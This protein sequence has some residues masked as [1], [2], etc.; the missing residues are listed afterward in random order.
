MEAGIPF[1]LPA[2]AFKAA[3]KSQTQIIWARRRRLVSAKD[4][5]GIH[6]QATFL[7]KSWCLGEDIRWMINTSV[8]TV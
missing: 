2:C 3:N 5:C 6:L 7:E 4:S 8:R 1:S